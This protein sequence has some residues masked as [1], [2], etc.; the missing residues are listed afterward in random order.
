MNKKL[1]ILIWSIVGGL[2]LFGGWYVVSF[3][4]FINSFG[5][6]F[7]GESKGDE[8]YQNIH[9]R[10][11]FHIVV[12]D[13]TLQWDTIQS[14]LREFHQKSP[15]YLVPDSLNINIIECEGDACAGTQKGYLFTRPNEVYIAEF[16]SGPW[17]YID[18]V[19]REIDGQFIET[20]T[21]TLSEEEKERIHQ[22][23]QTEIL[24]KVNWEIKHIHF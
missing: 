3:F 2:L 17:N 7:V 6:N 22:R 4:L 24:D 10:I 16:N 13:N 1:K 14:R 23:F 8:Y 9:N 15:E 5:E 12:C 18:F 19:Y 21:D 20:K 11:N